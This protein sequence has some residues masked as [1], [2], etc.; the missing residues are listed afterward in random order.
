MKNEGGVPFLLPKLQSE[1][2]LL[3]IAFEKQGVSLLYKKFPKNDEE[4]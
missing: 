3:S 2:G 4:D 1:E